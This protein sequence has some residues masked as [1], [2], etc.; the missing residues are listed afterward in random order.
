GNSSAFRLVPLRRR[1]RCRLDS[2]NKTA[3]EL[4][5]ERSEVVH[6]LL[7][8]LGAAYLVLAASHCAFRYRERQ[9]GRESQPLHLEP[10][11]DAPAPGTDVQVDFHREIAG[12]AAAQRKS[13]RFAAAVVTHRFECAN[14]D[15]LLGSCCLPKWGGS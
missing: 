3:V 8:T 15:R 6:N 7:P 5:D 12:S 11:G 1:P 10:G 4:G 2:R 9:A 13:P 14:E